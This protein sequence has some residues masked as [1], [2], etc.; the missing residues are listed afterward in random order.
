MWFALVS[1]F[2]SRARF[3]KSFRVS[4]PRTHAYCQE[5]CPCWVVLSYFLDI[6][7]F[8]LML[9]GSGAKPQFAIIDKIPK[10][11]S[12]VSFQFVAAIEPD[13]DF[14]L[15]KLKFKSLKVHA[16]PRLALLACS[17]LHI[18]P[19]PVLHGSLCHCHSCPAST[20]RHTS[21]A[22]AFCFMTICI[23]ALDSGHFLSWAALDTDSPFCLLLSRSY[24]RAGRCLILTACFSV[25]G[26]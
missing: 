23:T 5:T 20:L 18:S 21:L 15:K 16:A 25:L 10:G 9:V 12:R 24:F 13:E 14:N 17:A 6:F 7:C 3:L 8:S 2:V 26:R 19:T 1:L 11:S 4:A 22:H